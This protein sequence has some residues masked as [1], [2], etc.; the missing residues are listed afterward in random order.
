MGAPPPT[1]SQLLAQASDMITLVDTRA[2]EVNR[3]W[4]HNRLPYIVPLEWMEKFKRQKASW[5]LAAFE[6]TGSP[7][8]ADMERMRVQGQA[9]IRAY[10][11][12]EQIATES[13]KGPVPP[14]RWEFELKDGTLVI[15]VRDRAEM[16]QVDLHG[17]SAQ[18]W[19]LDEIAEVIHN[20][21]IL[22]AAKDIFP[23]A[24]V[25][26]VEVATSRKVKDKLDDELSDIPFFDR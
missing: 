19:S 11:K 17:R 3:R 18:V 24:E 20:F 15:L 13:G 23:A 9:M 25:L 21:P 12:L 16:A 14:E 10:D 4:G 2:K 7:L 5:E 26:E 22:S 8:P 6:C 1:R